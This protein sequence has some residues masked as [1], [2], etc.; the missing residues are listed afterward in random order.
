VSLFRSGGS[1]QRAASLDGLRALFDRSGGSPAGSV[2]VNNAT[3]L[4][5]SAVWACRRQRANLLSTLPVDLYRRVDGLQVEVPK[6]PLLVAPGTDG[7]DITSWLWATQWDLDGFGN[8]F[9]VITQRW[10]ASG[11]FPG[12]PAR[13]ELLPTAEVVVRGDGERVTEYRHGKD[14]W[15]IDNGRIGDVWHERLYQAPGMAV[16][17]NPVQQAALTL[18]AYLSAQ[19]FALAWFSAGGVP[20]VALK[21]TAVDLND[22][23]AEVAK[24]RWVA[25]TSQRGPAVLPKG[26]EIEMV[27]VP[28]ASSAYM[29]EKQWS[30]TDVAR[31]FDWPADL[32]DGAVSGSSVTYANVTQ[33]NLQ[34]LVMLLGPAVT[35]REAALSRA[36]PA[37]RFVKFNRAALLA[38]DPK[39][40]SEKLGQEVRDRLTAPSE[41]RLLMDRAP[42]TPEQIAEFE[43]LFGPPRQPSTTTGGGQA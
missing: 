37:P 40:V 24:R 8:A 29:A 38:M 23:Q 43:T 31:Y 4:R 6:P 9:G 2:V 34:A 14:K 10:G 30:V 19:E 3:A 27:D 41:A 7:Q 35:R 17:L 12:W 15:S 5:H 32:I 20:S 11:A 39:T 21:P 18:G 22:E 36:V 26:W 1:V 16:G 25:A 42:F 13:I 33:R 28:A